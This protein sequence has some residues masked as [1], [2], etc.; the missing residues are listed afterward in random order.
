MS[1][2]KSL[3]KLH[4]HVIIAMLIINFIITSTELP[5]TLSFLHHGIVF[6]ATD[7][8]CKFWTFYNFSL[9][10]TSEFL[11]TFASIERHLLVFHLHLVN[12]TRL[13]RI[14][15]HYIPL[16]F[17]LSYVWIFYFSTIIVY[18]YC[19]NSFS[20]TVMLC[21]LPCFEFTIPLGTYDWFAD[22]LTTAA[23]TA[24]FSLLLLLRFVLQQRRMK[25]TFKWHRNRKIV[26]QLITIATLYTIFWTPLSIVAL[27]QI[28]WI[29]TFLQDFQTEYLYYFPYVVL[30]L[31]Q[32]CKCDGNSGVGGQQVTSAKTADKRVT[33]ITRAQ[34]LPMN[35]IKI[36]NQARYLL[37][38]VSRY[39][40]IT[41][42]DITA[43][44]YRERHYRKTLPRTTI[45][46]TTL[47]RTTIP[48]TTLPPTP[49]QRARVPP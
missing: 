47:P 19:K 31:R 11:M 23:L 38:V 24:L 32:E 34:I 16:I 49:I 42:N 41:A 21:G 8:F 25:R 17:C 48:R 35:T 46:R 14:I 18:P 33:R 10:V 20:Y 45:P 22:N 3:K 44:Q 28:I 5:I 37:N 43:R 36:F 40:D 9:Q 29:P 4:N 39:S 7:G 26:L 12:G 2:R 30:I 15:L 6:P 27:I 1:S 13:R